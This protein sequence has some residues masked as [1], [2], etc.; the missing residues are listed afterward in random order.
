[1]RAAPR[2]LRAVVIGAGAGGLC[3]AIKLREAG[4][5]EITIIERSDGVGGTW[6]A[7]TYPGAACDVPSHLYSFSFALKRDWSRKYA[8]QPE[9]LS[10]FEDLADRYGL[11]PYLRTGL[12]V[13]SATFDEATG[14]WHLDLSDSSAITA[15]IVV[16]ATGQLSRP[17]IPDLPGLETFAGPAFHSATWDHDADLEAKRVAVVGTGASAVQFVPHVA[18]RAGSVS[19]FQRSASWVAPKSD[20]VYDERQQRLFARVPG[21]A[22][23]MRWY[24]YWRL[25][26][27]FA[28]MRKESRLGAMLARAGAKKLSALATPR[29]PV[30]ALVPDHRPGC[31]RILLSNDYYA[32]LLR[33][34]VTVELDPIERVEAG[35]IVTA[36]GRRT[37]AD[38][39]IFGTGFRAT[40]FLAPMAV[41]GRDGVSLAEAWSQGAEAH[42]GV[43]VAGFPNFFV[44]YGPNTNLG[45][46]SILFMIE[47]QARYMSQAV[48]RMIVEDLAWVEVRPEVM[49]RFTARVEREAERTIWATECNSWYKNAAGRITNNWPALSVAY[50]ARLRTYRPAEHISRPAT[51]S[52]PAERCR[53]E[54]ARL[55]E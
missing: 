15:E 37:E 38:V 9:I 6:R 41:T 3:A 51:R 43:E 55:G 4:V 12:A 24:V 48:R 29:L 45:H 30:E 35:A 40:E 5:H 25:E 13:T 21:A 33:P 49:D 44:M 10:Y 7:N 31:K 32:A 19:V 52:I 18:A 39:L 34:N 16:C 11:R 47:A 17:L 27:N 2:Q 26:M 53:D 14:I 28:L 42:L 54:R 20:Q 23:L 22:R 1:M 8:E 46:N 36:D 50:W